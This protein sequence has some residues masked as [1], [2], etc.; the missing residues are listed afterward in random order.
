M[1]RYV[2]GVTGFDWAANSSAGMNHIRPLYIA[3]GWVL[4][5]LLVEIHPVS[6]EFKDLYLDDTTFH[7]QCGKAKACFVAFTTTSCGACKMLAPKWTELGKHFEDLS[8][9]VLARVDCD[10]RT[11]KIGKKYVNGFP[12]IVF[13]PPNSLTEEQYPGNWAQSTFI[14][15]VDGKLAELKLLI[16]TPPVLVAVLEW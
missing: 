12:T 5:S 13:S 6:A 15:F 10:D 11:S 8:T 16:P 4:I 9:I 7:E 3:V 14:A 1:Y 2:L